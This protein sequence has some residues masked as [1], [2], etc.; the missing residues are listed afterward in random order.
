MTCSIWADYLMASAYNMS[1][2]LC[3]LRLLPPGDELSGEHTCCPVLAKG[4][5]LS[6]QSNWLQHQLQHEDILL[7]LAAEPSSC[8]DASAWLLTCLQPLQPYLTTGGVPCYP[9]C[10]YGAPNATFPI[11]CTPTNTS[12]TCTKPPADP[13]GCQLGYD[14]DVIYQPDFNRIYPYL[15]LLVFTG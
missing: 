13:S 12:S 3:R 15:A 7:P 10:T 2:R 1:C 14:P 5:L 8:S 6:L 9:D 4:C 11:C